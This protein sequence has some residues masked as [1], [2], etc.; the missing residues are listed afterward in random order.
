MAADVWSVTSY[1]ALYQDALDHERQRLLSGSG[2]GES[3]PYIGRCLDGKGD[4]VVAVSDYL[5]ALPYSL[6]RWI[7][8]PLN[9]LGTDGFGRSDAREDL[10]NYF[11]VDE[12][13][14]VVAALDGLVQAGKIGADVLRRAITEY[15]IDP[16]K[17]NP[18]F[19]HWAGG[20]TSPP[21]P[22]DQVA[23]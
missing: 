13:Y 15:G 16:G 2:P 1:K 6:S 11:E 10:R 19:C 20:E 7:K 23:K 21:V 3:R 9:S 17:I 5:K 8:E 14:V 22:E 18:M 4:A 12:R